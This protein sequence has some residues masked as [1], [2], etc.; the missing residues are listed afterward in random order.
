VAPGVSILASWSPVSPPSDVEGDNRTLNFNIISGTSMACPH[1]SGA[2]AYVKS[3]HPT[4][5]PAAIRSALMTTGNTRNEMMMRHIYIY[6][7]TPYF[8]LT[9]F[10]VHLAAKQ[11]RPEINL[12]AEFSYGA[13]Q[14]DPSKAVCP[15]L[16]YD[17]GEIDY[18]RFLCGQGYS[19]KILQLITGDNSSC[20]E[21]SSARDLNYASFA[22]FSPLSNSNKV[23]SGSFNRTVTNVGSATST[24]KANVIG[25]EG[26]KIEANP[27]VLSF[28]SLNQKLSFVLTIEGIIKEP[29]VSGSLTWDDG[30]FQVR[31]PIV[32]FNTA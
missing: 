14:I 12:Y 29:V 16:V 17:A 21:S 10:I 31:S 24:Y 25:P 8:L 19:S 13:G 15:G 23:I 32:V 28:T 30:K 3:F 27:S 20:S 2:A 5:S 22:L 26:L 11:L 7:S 9:L 4:W 1:V 18:V 6:I